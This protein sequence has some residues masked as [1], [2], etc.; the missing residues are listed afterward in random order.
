[1]REPEDFLDRWSRRKREAIAES[2]AVKPTDGANAPT[3]PADEPKAP[4]DAPFDPASLPPIESITANSDVRAFLKPGIPAE[5]SRAALRRAWSA[6]PAIRD[7]IGLVENG[8]DFN[9]PNGIPGFGT[10]PAGDVA[11]LLAQVFGGPPSEATAPQQAAVLQGSSEQTP[12][13]PAVPAPLPVPRE[14]PAPRQDIAAANKVVMQ[15]SEA[16][17]A[18]SQNNSDERESFP[19]SRQRRHGGALPKI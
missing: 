7:F 1:M 15:R 2:A 17:D 19:P 16:D 5:L 6:D 8:W 18:A 3:P 9:D 12:S 10:M 14:Q 4:A 11:R 13:E